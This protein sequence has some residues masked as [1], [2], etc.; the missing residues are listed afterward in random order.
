MIKIDIEIFSGI[1]DFASQVIFETSRNMLDYFL[2]I[3]IARTKT[4]IEIKIIPIP[5]PV[6]AAA[7]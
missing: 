2:S 7:A 4:V 3:S 1:L 5:V 6:Q